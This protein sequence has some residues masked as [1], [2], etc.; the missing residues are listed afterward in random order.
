MINEMIGGPTLSKDMFYTS[1]KNGGLRLRLLTERYQ[2]C[3][4]NT[5]ANFLQ[6]DEGTR[7]FIR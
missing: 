6:R 5:V 3:K 7:E 1:T 2:A 4:Y